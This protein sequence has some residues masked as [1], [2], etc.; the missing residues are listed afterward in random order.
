[1]KVLHISDLDLGLIF[2][3]ENLAKQIIEP[4]PENANFIAKPDDVNEHDPAWHQFGIITHTAVAY[5]AFKNELS[6]LMKNWELYDFI[7]EKLDETID[8][9][10]KKELLEFAIILHDIGK[11]Q[12]SFKIINGEKVPDYERH[13]DKSEKI[14]LD[15]SKGIYPLLKSEFQLTDYQIYYIAKCAGLHYEL[16]KIRRIAYD[17][18]GGFSFSY[19]NSLSCESNLKDLQ[20]KHKLFNIEIGILFLCD[21]L[22]KTNIRIEVESDEEIVLKTD[23]INRIITMQKL[24]PNLI[25]AVK[26]LP[27][28]MYLVYKY[29][30]LLKIA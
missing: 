17:E 15:K 16:G 20:L 10:S 2:S 21:N 22:A 19:I 24:H 7:N 8:G 6:D 14:I 25:R 30:L 26:Q 11:F 12:R 5:H 1:M 23:E 3:L 13:E 28:S 18:G 27:V 4:I 9:K 29:F